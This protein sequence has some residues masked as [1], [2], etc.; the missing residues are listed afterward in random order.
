MYSC[1]ASGYLVVLP[2]YFSW[3]GRE[4]IVCFLCGIINDYA[5]ATKSTK[6]DGIDVELGLHAGLT[7]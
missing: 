2:C 4:F 1:P 7:S 5:S 6:T 3:R